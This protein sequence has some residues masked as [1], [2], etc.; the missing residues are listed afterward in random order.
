M[1]ARRNIDATVLTRLGRLR[2]SALVIMLVAIGGC[3]SGDVVAART[4]SDSTEGLEGRWKV[5]GVAAEAEGAVLELRGFEMSLWRPCVELHGIWTRR[6]ELFLA[7]SVE[8][9]TRGRTTTCPSG[10]AVDSEFPRWLRDTARVV[11]ADSGWRLIDADGASVAELA[12]TDDLPAG[13][14]ERSFTVNSDDP[15]LR[16]GRVR[17]NQ[18]MPASVPAPL[19]AADRAFLGGAR[20]VSKQSTS[21]NCDQPWI[22]FAADGTWKGHN[23]GAGLHGRW[24][25]GTEGLFG[26][27]SSSTMSGLCSFQAGDLVADTN[28]ESWMLRVARV[29]RDGGDLLLLDVD[30]NQIV[31]LG[32]PG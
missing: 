29:A 12:P 11:K 6:A 15:S 19:S 23:E 32:R 13:V 18:T 17:A 31:R 20:W 26:A 8:G 2:L 30:G 28:V 27:T 1:Y 4:L 7:E 5:S 10:S 25:L 14:D 16:D 3:Q 24:N 21:T 22:K 9:R